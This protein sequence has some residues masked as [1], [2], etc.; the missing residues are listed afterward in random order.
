MLLP[1]PLDRLPEKLGRLY[2]NFFRWSPERKRVTLKVT[3]GEGSF[4]GTVVSGTIEKVL[5]SHE[6]AGMVDPARP[7]V[8]I[9]LD[10]PWNYENRTTKSTTWVVASPRFAGHSAYRLPMASADVNVFPGCEQG[11]APEIRWEDMIAIC[12]MKLS[13]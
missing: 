7:P 1:S 5:P 8:L 10:A 13:K 3:E 11:L 4:Y 12:E 6:A 2:A 9:R